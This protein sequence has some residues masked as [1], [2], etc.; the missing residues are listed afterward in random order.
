MISMP[1]LQFKSDHQILMTG[2]HRRY[3]HQPLFI[4]ISIPDITF[5]SLHQERIRYTNRQSANLG[6]AK[7]AKLTKK[8]TR[9]SYKS[10]TM[11]CNTAAP[12][13]VQHLQAHP[14]M[15]SQC[16]KCVVPSLHPAIST[17]SN[18]T[19]WYSSSCQ[20]VVLTYCPYYLLHGQKSSIQAFSSPATMHKTSN[21]FR[22]IQRTFLTFWGTVDQISLSELYSDTP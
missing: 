7:Q 14:W 21:Y 13:H 15:F 9:V 4:C 1:L 11:V 5:I 18:Y 2:A 10:K 19:L 16:H 17:M 6:T 3:T 8:R 20:H 22:T 12:G